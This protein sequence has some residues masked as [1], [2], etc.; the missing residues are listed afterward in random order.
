[1]EGGNKTLSM[2][3]AFVSSYPKPW[4]QTRSKIACLAKFSGG[5]EIEILGF[6]SAKDRQIPI[7]FL[8]F[9]SVLFAE[10]D[11]ATCLCVPVCFAVRYASQSVTLLD[12]CIEFVSEILLKAGRRSEL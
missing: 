6:F 3:P 10:S 2:L 12:G 8:E 9:S 4:T 7:L 1:M 5:D 11:H